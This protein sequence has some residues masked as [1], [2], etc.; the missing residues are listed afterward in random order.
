[1]RAS[2]S[3]LSDLSCLSPDWRILEMSFL[4]LEYQDMLTSKI[5]LILKEILISE[6]NEIIEASIDAFAYR[7]IG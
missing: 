7:L 5:G 6:L 3:A 4:F 2:D 1:M